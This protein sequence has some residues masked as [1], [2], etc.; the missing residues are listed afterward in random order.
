MITNHSML[1]TQ[2]LI[3]RIR[4]AGLRV[5]PQRLEIYRVLA[6]T[7]AHPTVQTLAEQ[8][9]KRLPALSQATIYNTLQ[10]MVELGL[11]Q[12]I[13]APGENAV[14]YDANVSPHAHLVCTRCGRV[15][16]FSAVPIEA[17]DPRVA[18][19]SGY[20]IQAI[21]I[22]YYGECPAC[23]AASAHVQDGE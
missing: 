4:Y 2:D 15:D 21:S 11:I 16:D 1:S 23:R 19:L 3:E 5:T 17:P 12:E 13:S 20:D 6:E 10:T 22:T 9:Q 8:L 18:E 7:T 14:R